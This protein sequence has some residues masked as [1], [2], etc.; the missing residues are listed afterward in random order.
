MSLE[1]GDLTELNRWVIG[2]RR[3]KGTYFR[4]VEYRYMNADEVLN[5]RGTEL[6]GG[7]FA[8][9]GTKAVYLAESDSAASN[10]V[11]ARKKRLGGQ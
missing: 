4:S 11:V 1:P 5:G 10:E 7:R 9:V 8:E 3:L 6:Y 2:G